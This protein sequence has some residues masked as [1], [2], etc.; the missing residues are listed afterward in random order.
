[1]ASIFSNEILRFGNK[2][3]TAGVNVMNNQH[4]HTAAVGVGL[5]LSF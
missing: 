1:M 5:S 2:S 4:T 3:L